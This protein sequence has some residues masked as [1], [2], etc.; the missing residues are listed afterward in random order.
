VIPS[1][2]CAPPSLDLRTHEPS[3]LSRSACCCHRSRY[4]SLLVVCDAGP[5]A[6]G[7]RRW[8]LGLGYSRLCRDHGD[9]SRLVRPLRH[10]DGMA[11]HAFIVA[12]CL[13]IAP[14]VA[15]G[16]SGRADVIDGDTLAIRGEP[17]RIRLYGIDA[18]EG[19]QTCS[20]AKGRPYLC[21]SRSADA[22]ATIIGRNGRVTCR[23]ED[24][25]RYGRI[26]ATCEA[27][28]RE[29][30]AEMVRQGWAVEYEQYS[31]GRYSD[32]EEE[33]QSAK[34]G[35]WAGTFVKPWEWRRGQR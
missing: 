10:G 7:T 31:D 21:G 19:K 11:S 35:L 16:L 6:G 3:N 34:R 26:V 18:P 8:H 25:D 12:I 5:P 23:E 22:L 13:F 20:D 15:Q 9:P 4:G 28:E 33:A 27:D 24:R 30:N 2:E 1:Q 29:I 17:A 32:E 14:A